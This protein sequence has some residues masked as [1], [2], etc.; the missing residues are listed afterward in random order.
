MISLLLFVF[1]TFKFSKELCSIG[2]LKCDNLNNCLICDS[3]NN[4]YRSLDNCLVSTIQNCEEINQ[5]GECLKCI[6][7]YYFDLSTEKCVLVSKSNRVDNCGL[8]S[9]SQ[10]CVY[11]HG[12]FIISK[13]FCQRVANKLLYCKVYS[14]NNACAVCFPGYILSNDYSQC[15]EYSANLKCM[16]YNY[17]ECRGCQSGFTVDYNYYFSKYKNE[18]LLMNLI[19]RFNKEP[20]SNWISQKICRPI[21]V[22]N[23]DLALTHNKCLNCALGYFNLA[24]ICQSNPSLSID[25]CV[26]YGSNSKCLKCSQGL[27]L[28]NSNTCKKVTPI[29]NCNTYNQSENTI[30]CVSCTEKYFL[31]LNQCFLRMNSTNIQNCAVT[32]NSNDNCEQCQPGFV[33]CSNGL[34]CA[35]EIKNC[36]KYSASILWSPSFT[37]TFCN[38]QFF[39]QTVNFQVNCVPGTIANCRVYVPTSNTCGQ[40]LNN[41]YLSNGIC[42][43]HSAIEN[44]VNYSSVIPNTC[45]S[46]NI[47]FYPFQISSCLSIKPILNCLKYTSDGTNCTQ[48][49]S[50]SY[51][52]N[53][54]CTLNPGYWSNCLNFTGSK[55][56]QC[57]S[58]YMLNS[59]NTT[60][61]CVI[62]FDYITS[63]CLFTS[64]SQTNTTYSWGPVQ[65]NPI[66]C[67]VCKNSTY[68][69]SPINS[70]AICVLQSQ[71]FLYSIP[72]LS[73]VNCFRYGINAD[74]TFVC[75]ECNKGLY[76]QNYFQMNIKSTSLT[77]GNCPLNGINLIIADDLMGFVNICVPIGLGVGQINMPGCSKVGRVSTYNQ[78]TNGNSILDYNCFVAS[79]GYALV[80]FTFPNYL[81]V[82]NSVVMFN[83][84]TSNLSDS[85]H[86]YSSTFDQ[87]ST[88]PFIFN[89]RGLSVSSSVLL[90]SLNSFVANGL[91][92]CEIVWNPGAKGTGAKSS[93]PVGLR[94]TSINQCLRCL[95]GN[96]QTVIVN[97]AASLYP[98]CVAFSSNNCSSSIQLGGLPSYLNAIFGCHVCLASSLTPIPTFPTIY[99]EYGGQGGSIDNN[100]WFQWSIPAVGAAS[101]FQ[102]RTAPNSLI[103]NSVQNFSLTID[104]VGGPVSSLFGCSSFG[105][106]TPIGTV[107][108]TMAI[109]GKIN[110]CLSCTTGMYPTYSLY[111]SINA[112]PTWAVSNCNQI[113]NCATDVVNG[114]FNSC[115][116]CKNYYFENVTQFNSFGDW[117]LSSCV[118]SFSPNC[119]I[120]TTVISPI[121]PNS[122]L[123]CFSGYYLNADGFCEIIIISN[124][125]VYYP[126]AV[127]FFNRFYQSV[128]QKGGLANNFDVIN[129][130]IHYLLSFGQIQYGVRGCLSSSHVLASASTF[131]PVLCVAS[132]Y[133]Q[134]SNFSVSLNT[135]FV[136]NCL[137][138]FM[139]LPVGSAKYNCASCNNELVPTL[140]GQA[141]V[142]NIQNCLI[143]QNYPLIFLCYK[144]ALGFLNILGNCTQ[145]IIQNCRTYKNT[146]FF[147]PALLLSCSLCVSG[148]FLSTDYSACNRG[149]VSNCMIYSLGSAKNCLQCSV[150]F[151]LINLSSQMSYCYPNPAGSNCD[152]FQIDNSNF[153]SGISRLVCSQC[154]QN[155][156]NVYGFSLSI[157][158]NSNQINSSCL[159]FNIQDNCQTYNQNS[160]FITYNSFACTSCVKGYWL[161][162]VHQNC[163]IRLNT[164]QNCANFSFSSDNCSSC[165]EGY[166]LNLAIGK[167][168]LNPIGIP[169]CKI[170]K[171]IDFCQQC[172]SPYYVS[173]NACVLSDIIIDNCEVYSENY[174]CAECKTGYFLSS[175][176]S[177]SLLPF[178]NCKSFSASLNCLEC[179]DGFNLS[180]TQN[181]TTCEKVNL[182]NCNKVVNGLSPVC[183]SCHSGYYLAAN[184]SCFPI[185]VSIQ[186]CLKYDTNQTC[187]LCANQTVLS[188]DRNA[189][190]KQIY[191]G[192][193]DE[194]CS[195]LYLNQKANCSECPIGFYFVN[196]TCLKCDLNS[197]AQ[198]CMICNPENQ[199]ECFICLPGYYQNSNGTC[200]QLN[201]SKTQTLS[202]FKVKSGSIQK[203]LNILFLIQFATGIRENV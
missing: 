75:M 58:N 109:S 119:F 131:A 45:S 60:T 29:L 192:K 22:E 140:N 128:V 149:D 95:F 167:C 62:P 79:A 133:L 47:G 183:Q 195:D 20:F 55:C 193:V 30:L 37:C 106:I 78:A 80:V 25:G 9:S 158:K 148:Y 194:K 93:Y 3:S 197:F 11:C 76:L 203:A 166:F 44:C 196:K 202:Y 129:I 14:S 21:E 38:D 116:K 110:V 179:E 121:I 153:N 35:P 51:L 56:F 34:V 39:L 41:F 154:S 152:F 200:V 42:L 156:T 137:T 81:L 170:Y 130:R 15:I 172:F 77:C 181:G 64:S 151:F 142:K 189:C 173:Q 83:V 96:Y 180:Q 177:C 161:S 135:N 102:C 144:C 32:S 184:L 99:L 136:P 57:V 82:D 53:G 52:M 91:A 87:N 168:V 49:T 12:D 139:S 100:L 86:G 72:I 199:S 26:S 33:L 6:N 165:S 122:C 46:C 88:N 74:G 66:T 27:Y 84:P 159:P 147:Q 7:E 198:G 19:S 114:P 104:S 134:N 190:I 141:C 146:V 117:M 31:N 94:I 63:N 18:T 89:F 111:S 157:D 188:T 61:D 98:S 40:C 73:V 107:L 162:P 171:S 138:Y 101:G 120:L 201:I 178:S 105:V 113:A 5:S 126:F 164:D 65:Q 124:G 24:G 155:Q 70:E 150:N 23:C 169:Q 185:Q 108:N 71:L 103:T 54:N 2:C 127:S 48:C 4:F 115:Q 118:L 28:F 176:I 69:F 132:N 186:N 13:G 92:F 191:I 187:V 90:T 112:I 8:Y 50:F 143:A 1:L 145:N 123:V 36:Q 16:T 67:L 182:P 175:S 125:S 174:L 68:P 59:F 97:P 43:A 160:S 10:A 163:A 17:I 85:G